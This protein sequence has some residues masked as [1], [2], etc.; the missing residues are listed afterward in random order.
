MNMTRASKVKSL[1]PSSGDDLKRK[2]KTA[3]RARQ[4][5]EERKKLI[6]IIKIQ[7]LFNIMTTT[8]P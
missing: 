2:G 4:R 7:F 1:C 3:H 5:Q 8:S 6:S